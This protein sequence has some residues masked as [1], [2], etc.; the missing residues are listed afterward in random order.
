M[1]A[2][3]LALR[4]A[5][6][7]PAGLPPSDPDPESLFGLLE[8]VGVVSPSPSASLLLFFDLSSLSLGD[9]KLEGD[10]CWRAGKPLPLPLLAGGVAD[11]EAAEEVL[12]LIFFFSSFS[13]NG[14]RLAGELAAGGGVPQAFVSTAAAQTFFSMVA[15]KEEEEVAAAAFFSFSAGEMGSVSR[16][17]P[18]P[19]FFAPPPFPCEGPEAAGGIFAFRVC[20]FRK[21]I[22]G[23]DIRDPSLAVKP[24][25]LLLPL[26]PPLLLPL[27]L[28]LLLLLLL[29]PPLLLFLPPVAAAAFFKARTSLP[30]FRVVGVS[31]FE[32]EL[33]GE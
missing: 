13:S 2:E 30:G 24:P 16:R 18:T 31:D 33:T 28:L 21:N 20:W 11:G 12:T 14:V 15:S 25:P 26:L 3:Q 32:P 6:L 23:M 29:L 9:C 4:T 10:F 22:T 1:E 17:G 19:V 7:S 5:A 27:P 8:D